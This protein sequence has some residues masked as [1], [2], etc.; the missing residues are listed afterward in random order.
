M[1]DDRALVAL[2]ILSAVLFF[3]GADALLK[4]LEGSR[5]PLPSDDVTGDFP[6]LPEGFSIHNGVNTDA[7]A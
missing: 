7:R 3:V 2:F 4:G 5:P 1:I 6:N